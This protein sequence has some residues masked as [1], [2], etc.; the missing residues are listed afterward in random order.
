MIV[1]GEIT[2]DVVRTFQHHSIFRYTENNGQLVL[3]NILR[4]FNNEH[5][6]VGYC[7][8]M[9]YVVATILIALVDPELKYFCEENETKNTHTNCRMFV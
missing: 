1:A 7:Q 6:A 4:R 9:N 3:E 2:R 8:G 5:W